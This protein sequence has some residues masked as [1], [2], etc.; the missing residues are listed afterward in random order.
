[1]PPLRSLTVKA[2]E[3]SLVNDQAEQRFLFSHPH[4]GEQVASALNPEP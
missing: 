3:Q 4:L 2:M 1:M